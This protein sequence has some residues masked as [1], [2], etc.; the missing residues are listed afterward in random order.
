MAFLG[1]LGKF[2]SC[3]KKRIELLSDDGSL[4]V[5]VRFA[6]GETVV[7]LHLYSA[8][9]PQVS[10]Q[11]GAVGSVNVHGEN[12]YRI[13]VHPDANNSAAVSFHTRYASQA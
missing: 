1:D 3:G 4:R 10:A 7:A 11:S 12:L 9:Q 6:P 8:T 13:V 5:L 2:T